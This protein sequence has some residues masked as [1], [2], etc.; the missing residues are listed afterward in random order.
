MLYEVITWAI[1]ALVGLAIAF[2]AYR[3]GKPMVVSISLYG[4]FGDKI[5]G[6]PLG[7]FVEFLAAFATIVITSYSIHYTKLYESRSI[8]TPSLFPR[9]PTEPASVCFPS[10][11]AAA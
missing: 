3:Q 6:S 7:R 8:R 9:R 4:L 5:I 10:V 11:S 1:F 2:P